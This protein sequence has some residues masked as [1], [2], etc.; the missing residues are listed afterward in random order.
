MEPLVDWAKRSVRNT[1]AVHANA[2]IGW[3]NLDDE[4]AIARSHADAAEIDGVVYLNGE[5]ELQPGDLLNAK[6]FQSDEY[7]LWAEPV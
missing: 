7:D 5:T 2:K 4:G 3:P 6:V 1:A